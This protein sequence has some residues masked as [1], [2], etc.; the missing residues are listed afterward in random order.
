VEIVANEIALERTLVVMVAGTRPELTSSD[1]HA[2]IMGH[3]VLPSGSFTVHVHHPEDF[4]VLFRDYDVLERILDAPLPS[5]SVRL[6]FRRWRKES[7]A[8][9]SPM[10]Y[11]VRLGI[12]GVPA[13]LWLRS[14]TQEILGSSCALLTMAPE[15][16]SKASLKKF[17]IT[18][19]C[20]HPYL[21][22]NEKVMWAPIPFD[23]RHPQPGFLL[24]VYFGAPSMFITLWFGFDY[25]TNRPLG[26][27]II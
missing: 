17:F 22:P 18:V 13:H 9:W 2:Y 24:T 8:E 1:V 5:S 15:T 6:V 23:A 26:T 11:R 10:D 25:G 4:L 3:F 12:Q 19:A 7:R 14:T 20:L 16:E 27:L 21:I